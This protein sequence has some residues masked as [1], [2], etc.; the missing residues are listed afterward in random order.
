M[1]VLISLFLLFS[2][3]MVSGQTTSNEIKQDSSE[4]TPVEFGEKDLSEFRTED[5]NYHEE[6]SE[7]TILDRFF[8]WLSTI[9]REF[10]EAIFGVGTATGFLYFVFRILPYLI[11]AFLLFL[12]IR[13]FINTNSQSLITSNREKGS[14]S[15]N[16]EAHII[17]NED[18]FLLIQKA[19]AD[20]NY[21]L[22]IRYYYLQCLK[23]LGERNFI[24][25][26]PQKTNEDYILELDSN[27]LSVPFNKLTRIYDFIWYGSFDIDYEHFNLLEDNFKQLI[28]KTKL[29]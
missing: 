29:S 21:R 3:Q 17:Q 9:L 16:E 23:Q 26:Q 25:W 13:F 6:A 11:L 19:I 18:I 27:E 7:P 12:L 10:W 14:I 1:K 22:A 15:L 2:L 24:D 28:A 8:K 5:F 4:I 20:M